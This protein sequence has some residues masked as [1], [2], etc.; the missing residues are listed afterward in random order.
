MN[1]FENTEQGQNSAT[2]TQQCGSQDRDLAKR[3]AFKWRLK[4][5]IVE[6]SVTKDGNA[7][8][9]RDPATTVIYYFRQFS[10]WFISPYTCILGF[11]YSLPFTR[12]Q[13]RTWF[14]CRLR[15]PR[16]Q[17]NRHQ[18]DSHHLLQSRHCNIRV[19][20]WSQWNDRTKREQGH[21]LVLRRKLRRM[22]LKVCHRHQLHY[23]LRS[24]GPLWDSVEYLTPAYTSTDSIERAGLQNQKRTW[25][26]EYYS[27]PN[28]RW[29]SLCIV[30]KTGLHLQWSQMLWSH[31]VL[32]YRSS[33]TTPIPLRVPECRY[34]YTTQWNIWLLLTLRWSQ[35]DCI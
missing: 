19:S 24:V 27:W 34:V 9:T 16:H 10:I 4:E 32:I 15:V 22:V 13:Q 12:G 25:I 3:Y 33:A 17:R 35:Q 2:R 11:V 6:E 14:D 20:K 30:A 26:S 7:F 1:S 8:Q 21:I 29:S 28:S 23:R 18:L 5:D 31:D